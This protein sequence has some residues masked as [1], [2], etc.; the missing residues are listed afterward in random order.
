[1]I[2][3]HSNEMCVDV[4]EEW[5]FVHILDGMGKLAKKRTI[6][7]PLPF[8]HAFF[9]DI[10]SSIFCW[11]HFNFVVVSMYTLN[12]VIILFRYAVY[13][14]HVL[15]VFLPFQRKTFYS[16][17]LSHSLRDKSELFSHICVYYSDTTRTN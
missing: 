16:L 14:V 10:F 2:T 8:L 7:H 9:V 17:A 13:R 4:V 3:S 5:K 12:F 6:L 15:H 11:F 1:M